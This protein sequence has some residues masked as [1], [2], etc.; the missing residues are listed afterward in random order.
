MR[1]SA[2]LLFLT[3]FQFPYSQ[4]QKPRR[5]P[6]PPEDPI[7]KIKEQENFNLNQ[8]AGKWFLIGVAS[9][10]DY[11]KENSYKLEGTTIVV[12]QVMTPQKKLPVS[13]FRKLDGICWEIKQEYQQDKVMG[14]FLL[15]AREYGNKLNMVVADTDYSSYSILFYQKQSKI[16][17]KLYG[18]CDSADQFHILN[19]SSN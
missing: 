11:L 4:G 10:C 16:S 19:E 3:L 17:V 15:T 13:T 14:R 5:P 9:E 12:S 18:F 6:K 2:A 7:G 8:F 1:P